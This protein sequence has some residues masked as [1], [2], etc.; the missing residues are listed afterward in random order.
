MKIAV[1]WDPTKNK[2]NIIKHGISFEEAQTVFYDDKAVEFYNDNNATEED[3][4]LLL[5]TSFKLRLLLICYCERENNKLRIITA[6]KATK[7]EAKEYY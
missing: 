4:F 6:R 1:E 2:K 7:T 5:G 3:R